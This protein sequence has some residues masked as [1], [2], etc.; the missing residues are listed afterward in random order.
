MKK[1][2]PQRKTVLEGRP[3]LLIYLL[4]C[5]V[6]LAGC[7]QNKVT[8]PRVSQE[9][10]ER[11]LTGKFVWYDIFT[12][13]LGAV[14]P[15]YSELFG[16]TFDNVS[17]SK[18]QV[19][20]ISLNG[21]PVGNAVKVVPLDGAQRE[22]MWLPYMSTPDVDTAVQFV[23]ENQGS[24]ATGPKDL[25]GRGRVAVVHDPGGALFALLHANGGDPLD[26]E[27]EPFSWLGGELWTR[28]M[29]EATDFYVRL[30]GYEERLV[31]L[32]CGDTYHFLMGDGEPRAGV[33]K[34][35]W[36]DVEPNWVPYVAV[37]DVVKIVDKA[38]ALGATLLME[39]DTTYPDNEVALLADPSGAVFGVQQIDFGSIHG[40]DKQ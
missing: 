4:T 23:E 9:M 12:D 14:E 29:E 1:T 11:Q 31:P 39:P 13:D 16:W 26:D 18:E 28:D 24:V 32:A 2:I 34:I 35:L 36:D 38:L 37:D 3:P 21:V 22:S 25:Q 7:L 27:L 5:C 17:G 33:A 10:S 19:K 6:I 8:L 15:F 20:T 40:G 30:A